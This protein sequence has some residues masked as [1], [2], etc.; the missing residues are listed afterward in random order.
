[1]KRDTKGAG[2]FLILFMKQI[3]QKSLTIIP[4][5][6]KEGFIVALLFILPVTLF[7]AI[8]LLLLLRFQY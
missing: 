3:R 6:L 8:W 7:I 2:I 4:K 1:M 5:I